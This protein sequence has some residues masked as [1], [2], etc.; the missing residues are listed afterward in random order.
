MFRIFRY[1]APDVDAIELH[2]Q[3]WGTVEE[4]A[5]EQTEIIARPGSDH[6]ALRNTWDLENNPVPGKAASLSELVHWF[7]PLL[8]V[9]RLAQ[10]PGSGS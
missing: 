3:A 2:K 1:S 7:E 10:S 9:E 4:R 5:L 6:E 8:R